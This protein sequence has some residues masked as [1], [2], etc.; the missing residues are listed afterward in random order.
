[1]KALLPL[2]PLLAAAAILLAGNGLQGTLITLRAG[3]EGFD[4]S[5]IGLMG[6]GYYAGFLLSCLFTARLIRAVGHIR[7]F[8]GLAAIA[9]S[10]SLT[11]V[12]WIDPFSWIGLR[13]LTGYCFAGLFMVVDSWL[14]AAVSNEARART[15]S[16]YRMV[17]LAAVTGSQ[18]LL[19]V[20]GAGGFPI[21]A[22]MAILICLSLVPISLMDR[23]SPTPPE[24]AKFSIAAVWAISPLACIGCITI[25]L[26]N[27][28]FRLMGPLYASE[29]GFDTAGVATF[30][31][32]GIVGGAA[33][34]L[35]LGW[36]SDRLDRRWV[37]IVATL[38]AAGSG[39]I[40]SRYGS[41][42]ELAALAGIF[43][44]GAFALPLYSLSAAHAND[45]AKPGQYV[46]LAAG[47]SFF[48]SIGAIAGP[49][50][51][52]Q[53]LQVF[54]TDFFFMYTSIIHIAFVAVTV[55]R[56]SARATP[57]MAAKKRYA[58]LLRT[59]PFMYKLAHQR[60]AARSGK[61]PH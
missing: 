9:A 6:A 49:V 47:L 28:T 4:A 57:D 34:Q 20:F 44:F 42:S 58:T 14:N 37:L 39:M 22:I 17:D 10:A 43:L 29:I 48:F 40:L 35:P 52:A 41:Q 27:S 54:G 15:L 23:S 7:V 46:I 60:A 18:F 56:M 11:M 33:L 32:A 25:G 5:L 21:F 16:V 3:Q 45:H 51:A 36:L 55:W 24:E 59:S 61:R 53:V 38:G 19:P 2:S 8:A 30:M 50:V 13:F 1:M 26:T 12:L 31:S